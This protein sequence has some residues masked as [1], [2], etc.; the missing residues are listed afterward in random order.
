MESIMTILRQP[1]LRR[2]GLLLAVLGAY[3]TLVIY[4]LG[5]QWSAYEQYNYGWAVPF[6]CLFLLW[7]RIRNEDGKL[8]IEN[9]SGELETRNQKPET[10]N[11]NG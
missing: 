8:K 1:F 4:Q 6:L 3:W 5:A 2:A 7:E 11:R 9:G 10:R